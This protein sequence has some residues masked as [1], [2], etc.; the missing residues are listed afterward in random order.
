MSSVKAILLSK[1][2]KLAVSCNRIKYLLA[3]C[4]IHRLIICDCSKAKYYHW[5]LCLNPTSEFGY[6]LKILQR[7]A[8]WCFIKAVQFIS[9]K[10][11]GIFIMPYFEICTKNYDVY[12]N[13]QDSKQ[14]NSILWANKGGGRDVMERAS[15]IWN[16]NSYVERK[17]SALNSFLVY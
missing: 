10:Q 11:L 17:I 12:E 13:D 4:R 9:L 1:Q 2:Q 7:N 8:K 16:K 14:Y 15:L 5:H 6:L 3:T